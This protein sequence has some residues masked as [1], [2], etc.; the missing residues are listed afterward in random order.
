MQ[1]TCFIG[2][3]N[4]AKPVKLWSKAELLR[5]LEA[6]VGSGTLKDHQTSA[7]KHKTLQRPAIQHVQLDGEHPVATV[8]FALPQLVFIHV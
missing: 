5:F 6:L 8:S 4:C 2:I 3:A 1:V 7:V